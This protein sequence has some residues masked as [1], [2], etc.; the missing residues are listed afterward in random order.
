MSTGE[1]NAG[2]DMLPM[3]GVALR[4]T[5]IPSGGG[6][7]A[8]EILLVASCYRNRISTRLMGHLARM[9]TLPFY[10]TIEQILGLLLRR[11]KFS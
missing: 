10:L 9:Q 6:G 2:C 1:F 4:W 11:T 5:K 7:E 8:V 3:L